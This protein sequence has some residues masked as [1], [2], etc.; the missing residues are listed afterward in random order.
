M[1]MLSAALGLS[2]RLC[3]PF[4][5]L[6][7]LL[8]RRRAATGA[9]P[10]PSSHRLQSLGKRKRAHR[11]QCV[12][13]YRALSC[14]R[15]YTLL[16]TVHDLLPRVVASPATR[17]LVRVPG[18][19]YPCS[20]ACAPPAVVDGCAPACFVIHCVSFRHRWLRGCCGCAAAASDLPELVWCAV[21]RTDSLRSWAVY[22]SQQNFP[23]RG[24]TRLQVT[25]LPRAQA[26]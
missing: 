4:F 3:H 10:P 2:Y 18:V 9:A 13:R 14:D 8:L 1:L 17:A 12:D 23:V 26:C 24:L 22:R 5:F 21:L 6:R 20:P 15:A 11:C 25:H 7:S 19:R 16:A